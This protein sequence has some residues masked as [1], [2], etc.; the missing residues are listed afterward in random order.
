MYL[1]ANPGREKTPEEKREIAKNYKPGDVVLPPLPARRARPE[2]AEDRRLLDE[3]RQLSLWSSRGTRS[4][5]AG[6]TRDG[7]PGQR[8]RQ[9]GSDGVSGRHGEHRTPDGRTR[10]RESSRIPARDAAGR[11]GGSQAQEESPRQIE[12]QSSLRSM[13]SAP[14]INWAAIEQEIA[15]Q[16]IE[17]GLLDDLDLSNI[18]IS[19]EDEIS[20]RIAEAY[21]RRQGMRPRIEHLLRRGQQG[22]RPN[23]REGGTERRQRTHSRSQSASIQTR[24]T[25]RTRPAGAQS[26]NSAS[27][28]EQRRTPAGP[29]RRSTSSI[30]S[31]QPDRRTSDITQAAVRSSI[32][33][34]HRPHSFQTPRTQQ[35]VSTD[36]AQEGSSGR[37]R[38]DAAR[39]PVDGSHDVGGLNSVGMISDHHARIDGLESSQR[40]STPP[41]S[42]QH[43]HQ[44][45]DAAASQA[46][47]HVDSTSDPSHR[48]TQVAHGTVT[49][50]ARTRTIL[51]PEPSI[52]CNRCQKAHIEYDLHYNCSQCDNCD[53]NLCLDCYRQGRGCHHWYGFGYAAWAKYERM[54]PAGGY[55]PNHP[56]PH[57]LSGHRY[58][59]PTQPSVQQG[60]E[61]SSNR[62]SMTMMT[63]E[64]PRRRLQ[65]G[66]FCSM[67][68][69]FANPCFW[70]CDT[71]NEGEWGFCNTCINTGHSCTHFLLPLIHLSSSPKENSSPTVQDK[72]TSTTTPAF[73]TLLR[74]PWAIEQGPLKPLTMSTACNVCRLPIQP[75]STRY[76]CFQ[77]NGGDYDICSPCYL[78]LCSNGKITPENGS[79]GWR[80]CL[81]G[82]RMI[83]VG[84]EDRD[85]G[86]R[87]VVVR[88]LVGGWALKEEVDDDD[89]EDKVQHGAAAA[90]AADG[91]VGAAAGRVLAPRNPNTGITARRNKSS[92]PNHHSWTWREGPDGRRES[93]IISHGSSSSGIP[94]STRGKTTN[95]SSGGSSTLPTPSNPITT[96]AA[97]AATNVMTSDATPATPHFPPDGGVGM[98]VLAI[99]S[100]YPAPNVTDELLFPR[101]A[102][103]REVENINGD[104]Y[105]GCYAG[106]KGLFPGPYVTVIDM[107]GN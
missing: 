100:Y 61:A 16:I 10:Q 64:D 52:S 84:F 5:E 19:E 11:A 3:V 74:D 50:P 58:L 2:D 79:K 45:A 60:S 96:N 25:R 76:H 87:R 18:D 98:R 94:S 36:H 80:R 20:E 27:R 51:Y 57:T 21:R 75:S 34:S 15:R 42:N 63:T 102:E 106:H 40:P 41:L 101:G 77:C 33:G 32:D 31:A 23:R 26:N 43:R 24:D 49:T 89:A 4:E 29:T 54:A 70:K 14:D 103:I 107:V 81:R 93:K 95:S 28:D 39:G 99:W 13:L 92:Q 85:G 83:V 7:R 88:D 104:W 78:K 44:S 6:Q 65:E 55:A 17:D 66:V 82:H 38:S 68:G 12:H 30:P 47:P 73:A 62:R 71:C 22:E 8:R 72:L 1:L 91:D 9:S 69:N 90:A 35:A 105:W 37:S 53:F 48:N 56:L 67:C 59:R 46:R 86:R 97:A